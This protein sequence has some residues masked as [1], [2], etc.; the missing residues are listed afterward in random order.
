MHWFPGF[1]LKTQ[2]RQRKYVRTL[3][4]L[5]RENNAINYFI[6]IVY[7]GCHKINKST[8]QWEDTLC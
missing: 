8:Q 5:V 2:T 6:S 3:R 4:C 7:V 1:A